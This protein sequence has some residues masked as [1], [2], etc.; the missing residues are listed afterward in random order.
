M[1]IN[2]SYIYLIISI[3]PETN[4]FFQNLFLPIIDIDF[5]GLL[6]LLLMNISY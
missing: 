1:I 4:P 5:I 3:N 2:L 6:Y